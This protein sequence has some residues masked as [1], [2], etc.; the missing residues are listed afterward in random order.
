[1][2]KPMRD[3]FGK[4]REIDGKLENLWLITFADL[5]VQL[6]A[7]F[8]IIFSYTSLYI[9]DSNA[10]IKA[11]QEELGV[12]SNKSQMPTGDGILPGSIGIQSDR[13]SDLEKLIAEMRA[14]EGP[15][16]GVHLRVITFRGSVL[17]D[18]GSAILG[19]EFQ[20]WLDRIAELIKAYPGYVVVL[21]GRAAPRERSRNGGDVWTLSGERAQAVAR[22]LAS[23]G[24][25]P[26]LM[27]PESR[28]DSLVE[29]DT[30]SQEA[31]A[32]ARQVRFRFQRVEKR[33]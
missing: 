23:M 6:M 24:V 2:V 14:E 12:K 4:G 29:G 22:K 15:D 19:L 7:F 28:G 30:S 33:E 20:P 11:L 3:L 16:E 10:L 1:M 9:G 13:A 26:V 31:R 32:L 5:M 17:F 18:E 21:E 8:A 25:E 27:V